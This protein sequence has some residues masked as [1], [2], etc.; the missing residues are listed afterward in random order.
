MRRLCWA[1]TAFDASGN[2][3]RKFNSVCF[4]RDAWR[5][6][7]E[8][9]YLFLTFITDLLKTFSCHG[10]PALRRSLAQALTLGQ[11]LLVLAQFFRGFTEFHTGLG[12]KFSPFH[13]CHG[14]DTFHYP[15]PHPT[16]LDTSRD[17][18]PQLWAMLEQLRLFCKNS[19]LF[20]V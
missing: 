17:G 16:C 15:R 4:Q 2:S 6:S 12:W 19:E 11:V 13:P 1:R 10:S 14:L 5:S 18:Q 3:G 20:G 7:T 8:N 9:L